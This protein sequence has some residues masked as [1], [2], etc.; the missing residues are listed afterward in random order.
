MCMYIYTYKNRMIRSLVN[1]ESKN[2]HASNDDI[3]MTKSLLQQTWIHI[4]SKRLS[5]DRSSSISCIRISQIHRRERNKKP[6]SLY[7]WGNKGECYAR[8]TILLIIDYKRQSC[9][10]T[11]E[12]NTARFRSA[13]SRTIF[14]TRRRIFY[15]FYLL[16]DILFNFVDRPPPVHH[17]WSRDSFRRRSRIREKFQRTVERGAGEKKEKVCKNSKSLT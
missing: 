9:E 3:E 1:F 7:Y 13:S 16:N 2:D 10:E 12:N 4:R 8:W 17:S 14:E 15:E 6:V 11:R 5:P